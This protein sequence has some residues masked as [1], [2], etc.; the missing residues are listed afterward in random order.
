MVEK[1]PTIFIRKKCFGKINKMHS[2]ECDT[3][4]VEYLCLQKTINDILKRKN[5]FDY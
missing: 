4:P 1:E 2:L 3:C 5:K